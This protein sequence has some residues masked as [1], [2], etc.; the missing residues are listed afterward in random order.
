MIKNLLII[1]GNEYVGFNDLKSINKSPPPKKKYSYIYT[2]QHV[3]CNECG[4]SVLYT[5][6]A[7][8]K[9]SNKHKVVNNVLNDRFDI[10]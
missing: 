6:K 10:K 1:D 2:K 5:N 9:K 8:H 3:E 4:A 7:R